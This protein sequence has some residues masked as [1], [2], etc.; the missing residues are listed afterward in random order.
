MVI[1]VK[2]LTKVSLI[3]QSYKFVFRWL[4][5]TLSRVIE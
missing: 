2:Q 3:K 4:K 1:N 5:D